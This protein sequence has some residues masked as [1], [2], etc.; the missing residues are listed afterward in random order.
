MSGGRDQHPA[1][2]EVTNEEFEVEDPTAIDILQRMSITL[3]KIELHL[4]I[5]SGAEVTDQDV[6]G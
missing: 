4:S 1:A 6:G 5:L 2:V 3:E